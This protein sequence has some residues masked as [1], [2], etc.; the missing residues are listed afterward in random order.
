MP[1]L[2]EVTVTD[3]C[4]GSEYDQSAKNKTHWPR[5]DAAEVIEANR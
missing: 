3:Q 1:P 2:I 5:K 4:R